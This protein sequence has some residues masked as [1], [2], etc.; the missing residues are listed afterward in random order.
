MNFFIYLIVA[1]VVVFI[2]GWAPTRSP[3]EVVFRLGIGRIYLMEWLVYGLL[4]IYIF[5]WVMNG[6]LSRQ[7]NLFRETPLDKPLLYFGLMMP[8]FGLYGLLRG[9]PFQVAFGYWEW[10]SLFAAIVFYFLFTSILDTS[11]K[12]RRLFEWFLVLCAAKATYYLVFYVLGLPYPFEKII[13]AGPFDEGPETVMF[14]FAALAAISLWLFRGEKNTRLQGLAPW[15]ALVLVANLAISA[16]RTMQVGLVLGLVVL[17]L[18]LPWRRLVRSASLAAVAAVLFTMLLGI[19]NGGSA[20]TGVSAS[21]SRYG[22]VLDFIQDPTRLSASGETVAFHVLDMLDV[23]GEISQHPVLG[24]GFGSHYDRELT[25]LPSVGG[26]GL[27]Y[28]AGMVHSQYLYLWWKMGALGLIGFLYL[29]FSVLRFLKKAT[30][31]IPSSEVEAISLGLYGFL[32]ADAFMEI[33]GPQW[34]TSTKVSVVMLMCVAVGVCIAREKLKH[35]RIAGTIS[36]TGKKL[37]GGEEMPMPGD[38]RA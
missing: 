21:A 36:A 9:N 33:L 1:I 7:R 8:V 2:D 5:D 37:I 32:W 35:T 23:W 12:A 29:L 3:E 4:A 14:V 11:S 31:S 24:S 6:G 18:R 25:L 30:P 13:G 16:K 38:G 17:G 10:R 20:A 34:F 15:A 26:E 27:G 28:E 22:E 19:A